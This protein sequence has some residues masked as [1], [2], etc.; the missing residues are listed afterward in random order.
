MEVYW[1]LIIMIVS[2]VTIYMFGI[3]AGKML[4]R[5]AWNKL[6]ESGVLPK[7]EGNS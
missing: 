6:I 1:F 2:N 5:A 4:E 3:F 7:P